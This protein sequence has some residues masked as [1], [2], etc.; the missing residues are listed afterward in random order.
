MHKHRANTILFPYEAK[1][2]EVICGAELILDLDPLLVCFFLI[3][4]QLYSDVT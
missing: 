3:A 1:V 2:V 4:R